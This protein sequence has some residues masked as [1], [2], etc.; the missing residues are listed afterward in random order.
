[1]VSN[2][3]LTVS[4]NIVGKEVNS[5]NP[6]CLTIFIRVSDHAEIN[7]N[8]IDLTLSQTSLVFTCLQYKS[9]ENIVGKGKIVRDNN[10][11]SLYLNQKLHCGDYAGSTKSIN[12]NPFP[13]NDTF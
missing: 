4:E 8:C 9:F 12:F 10:C 5:A 2:T 1:M 7:I 3:G 6:L 13:N 11:V